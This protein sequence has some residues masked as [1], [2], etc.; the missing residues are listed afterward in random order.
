MRAETL[1]V[2]YFNVSLLWVL[3]IGL[4]V[5]GQVIYVLWKGYP[6]FERDRHLI[7]ERAENPFEIHPFLAVRPKPSVSVEDNGMKV[8][9]TEASTRWTGAV[10]Q[11][12]VSI[13]VALLG[14]STT[15][16]S[17]VSDNDTWAARLQATL[18]SGYR[19]LRCPRLL[20]R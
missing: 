1:K 6:L 16:G 13:E 20:E 2:L 15:F 12:A 18:G 14:G 7:V 4:E 11:S 17:G 5:G 9:T 10:A 8:T 3:L 19:E